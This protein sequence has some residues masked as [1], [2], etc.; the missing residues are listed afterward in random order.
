MTAHNF[1]LIEQIIITDPIDSKSY[2]KV[3]SADGSYL[4]T[5]DGYYLEMNFSP[6]GIYIS[7]YDSTDFSKKSTIKMSEEFTVDDLKSSI[8]SLYAAD[9]AV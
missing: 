5:T 2:T 3:S 6:Y 7:L 9:P 4:F 8:I 1:L